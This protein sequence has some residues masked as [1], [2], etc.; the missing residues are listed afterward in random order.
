M[1]LLMVFATYYRIFIKRDYLIKME[2]NCDPTK[3]ICLIKES[4]EENAS[5]VHYK[6]IEQKAYSLNE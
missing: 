2:V 6:I 1:V 3:E 4:D 5:P